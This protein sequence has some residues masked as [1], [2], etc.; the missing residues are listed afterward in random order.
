MSIVAVVPALSCTHMLRCV[1]AFLDRLG[2]S[3][4]CLSERTLSKRFGG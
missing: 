4:R 2:V 1:F 3:L